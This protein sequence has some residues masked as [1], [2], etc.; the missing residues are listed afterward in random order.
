LKPSFLFEIRVKNN[1]RFGIVKAWPPIPR[2]GR[3]PRGL[4]PQIHGRTSRYGVFCSDCW[5]Y[6]SL[7]ALAGEADFPELA[8]VEEVSAF[9]LPVFDAL[10]SVFF[11]LLFV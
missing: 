1:H 9:P 4:C 5:D 11:L 6:E 8:E 10:G 7:D 3:V 2:I